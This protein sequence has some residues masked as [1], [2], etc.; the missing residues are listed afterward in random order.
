MHIPDGFLTTPLWLSLDVVSAPLVGWFGRRAQ[1]RTDESKAPLLGLMGAFVFA[2]QM[3]NSPVGPGTSGHLL[4]AALLA[5]TLGPAAAVVVMTAVLALQALV[6]QDGGLLALGANVFNMAVCGVLAGYVPYHYWG[7][8]RLRRLAVFAGGA[9]SVFVSASLAIVELLL[10]GIRIPGAVLGASMLVFAVS[11]AIEGVITVAVLEALERINPSWVEKRPEQARPAM[12]LLALAA[13]LLVTIGVLFASAAPDGLE[14][15]AEE[16]G[17][18]ERARALFESPLADYEAA[19]LS[20][21]W[22]AQATA[23]LVGLALAAAL[24]WA[25]A[26]LITRRRRS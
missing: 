18:S 23:G 14:K 3:I 9:L 19:F 26:R 8:G 25:L 12:G 17:V 20:G 21:S 24:G 15:L 11:A 16:A 7:V 4:G 6:F 1:D 2:A 10:S 22:A 5:F 13:V